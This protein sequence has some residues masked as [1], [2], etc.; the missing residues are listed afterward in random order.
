MQDL[1]DGKRAERRGFRWLEDHGIA[2]G[3]RRCAFPAGDLL[4]IVPGADADADAERHALGVGEITAERDVGTVEAGSGDA[5][6]ELEAVG[7]RCRVCDDR[8]LDRLAGIQCLQFGQLSIALAHD[9]GGALEDAAARR[10]AHR[11]PFRLGTLCRGDCLFDDG[12]SC[13]VQPGDDLAGRR[14]DAFDDA[15][16]FILDI[17]AVDVVGGFRLGFEG[18]WICPFARAASCEWM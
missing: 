3:E 11:G 7:A 17:F 6:E 10:R 4:R 1:S 15:A 16:G 2:G 18:H 14:I 5:A 13:R 8:F 12:G 9:V